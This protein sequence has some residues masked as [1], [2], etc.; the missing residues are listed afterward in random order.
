M[1]NSIV[2]ACDACYVNATAVQVEVKAGPNKAT[3]T[4]ELCPKCVREYH[5]LRRLAGINSL[6]PKTGKSFTVAE[7][8]RWRSR[9]LK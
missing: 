3:W 4:C 8:S 2:G 1:S 5:K 9:I 6:N 7:V